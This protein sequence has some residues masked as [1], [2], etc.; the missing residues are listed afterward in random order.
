VTRSL[1]RRAVTVAP[2]RASSAELETREPPSE[3]DGGLVIR[4]LAVGI[5][6]TDREILAGDYGTPPPGC[7]RLILGHEFLGQVIEAP[8][9]SAFDA[10]DRVAGIV[11]RPDPEPCA[12]CAAGEW[13][14]C[15]NG[16]YTERG[17]KGRDGYAAEFVRLEPEYAIRVD[18]QLGIAGVLTEPASVVAKAWAEIDR[19]ASRSR[20]SDS[21]DVLVTGAGPIG[22]LAAMMGVQRGHRVTV[23]DRTADGPKPELV[24]DLGADYRTASFAHETFDIVL[25]C[26]GVSSVI[27]D[28]FGRLRPNGILCLTGV[29]SGGHCL[30]VDIGEVNREM[31]LENTIVFGSV[32]ARRCHYEAGVA[33]LRRADPSWLARLI[34]R[35]VTLDDWS[36][37]FERRPG[38]V[39]VVLDFSG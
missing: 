30:T 2:G 31:V 19:F 6:G 16:R 3:Q 26:T 38:D 22:L 28:M 27:F 13:D 14:L 33:S 11:R 21:G 39:K 36:A 4:T 1:S 17:I 5:C 12:H 37:A 25:E 9:G 34:T 10:G 8:D 20:V 23:Y 24:R 7:E 35:R 29:S 15:S 32:N 18:E